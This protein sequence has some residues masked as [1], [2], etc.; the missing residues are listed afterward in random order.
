M[1]KTNK[2]NPLMNAFR[3]LLHKCKNWK[4][5]RPNGEW[6]NKC[7]AIEYTDISNNIDESQT[8]YTTVIYDMI[9]FVHLLEKANL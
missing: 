6:I 9:P 5:K 3:N 1:P 4:P 7:G 8:Y 2:K